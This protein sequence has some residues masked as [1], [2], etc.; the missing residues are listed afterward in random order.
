MSC[1]KCGGFLVVSE[2]MDP[3]E[4]YS[5]MWCQALRCINCG[6]IEEA[7]IRMNREPGAGQQSALPARREGR[8]PRTRAVSCLGGKPSTTRQ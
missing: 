8:G 6:S 5:R 3:N 4:E 2:L 7:R 1:Q